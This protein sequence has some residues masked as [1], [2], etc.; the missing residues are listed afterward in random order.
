MPNKDKNPFPSDI[1]KKS[2]PHPEEGK[3]WNW[4][5][6]DEILGVNP[7]SKSEFDNENIWYEEGYTDVE[8]K[9]SYEGKHLE[10]KYPHISIHDREGSLKGKAGYLYRLFNCTIEELD[11]E[12]ACIIYARDCIIRK[13]TGSASIWA[14]PVCDYTVDPEDGVDNS[15][16]RCPTHDIPLTGSG[17]G[18]LHFVDCKIYDVEDVSNCH[19]FFDG[20]TEFKTPVGTAQFNNISDSTLVIFSY[21]SWQLRDGISQMTNFSD[22]HLL[23]SGPEEIYNDKTYAM[24]S[25]FNNCTYVSMQQWF[26]TESRNGCSQPAPPWVKIFNN[27]SNCEMVNIDVKINNPEWYAGMYTEMSHCNVININP[28][29]YIHADFFEG[30]DCNICVIGGLLRNCDIIHFHVS[31]STICTINTKILGFPGYGSILQEGNSDNTSLVVAGGK[32]E[33]SNNAAPIFAAKDCSIRFYDCEKIKQ[34]GPKDLF[35]NVENCI[36]RLV[37]CEE[38]RNTKER[39]FNEQKNCRVDLLGNT[40]IKADSSDISIMGENC[41]VMAKYNKNILAENKVF[42]LK[43][44]SALFTQRNKLI[45]SNTSEAIVI[46]NNSYANLNQD[47]KIHTKSGS[48]VVSVS[49]KSRLVSNRSWLKGDASTYGLSIDS[50]SVVELLRDKI[51]STV[52]SVKIVDSKLTSKWQEFIANGPVGIIGNT[53]YIDILEGTITSS[54]EEVNLT[55]CEGNLKDITLLGPRKT[56]LNHSKFYV[57]NQTCNILE[58]SNNCKVF[59]SYCNI[60]DKLLVSDAAICRV[61]DSDIENASISGGL[62][63]SSASN[64]QVAN[65]TSKLGLI[66][67]DNYK[68]ISVNGIYILSQIACSGI[69]ATGIIIHDNVTCDKLSFPAKRGIYATGS[70][71]FFAVENVYITSETADIITEA[72][73]GNIKE[74]AAINISEEAGANISEEAGGVASTNA[75]VIQH[76]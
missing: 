30:S 66:T 57:I 38:I 15:T 48:I 21:P 43:D 53:S 10:H 19:M 73:I 29:Y 34:D 35:A 65:F 67:S 59:M 25:N 24:H 74:K 18:R 2:P 62:L 52:A 76:N 71:D 11:V 55:D 37:N 61:L 47:D 12:G 49:N 4:E 40:L 31:D 14:C 23:V 69:T 13:I 75:S 3:D 22:C 6:D 64:Y 44:K 51:E 56:V 16:L 7:A 28:D 63:F 58:A 27:F 32:L 26:C 5:P 36:T 60:L 33:V 70:L 54:S 1:P 8:G 39:L 45:S 72:L 46:E 68:T 42:H 17:K 50:D 20:A 9:R 41:V